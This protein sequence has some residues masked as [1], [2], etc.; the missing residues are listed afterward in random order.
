MASDSTRLLGHGEGQG[1][2]EAANWWELSAVQCPFIQHPSPQPGL[3]ILDGW[4][5]FK[6]YYTSLKC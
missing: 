1:G 3:P 4:V 5:R 6:L 2:Q